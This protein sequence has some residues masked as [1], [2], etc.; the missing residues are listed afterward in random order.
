[1]PTFLKE[2]IRRRGYHRALKRGEAWAL[3]RKGF[4]DITNKLMKD[5]IYKE[6]PFT[7]LLG[8]S[9]WLDEKPE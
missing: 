7:K 3:M 8:L 6:S 2:P 4:E 1:M 5:M 9:A